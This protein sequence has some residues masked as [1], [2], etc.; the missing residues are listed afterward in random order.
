MNILVKFEATHF[1]LYIPDG[2]VYDLELLQNDFLKWIEDQSVYRV[3]PGQKTGICYNANT[4]LQY[5][6]EVVLLNSGERAY[7]IKHSK[8]KKIPTIVF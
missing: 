7:F 6:N 1:V 5:L 2:Y 3:L 4:F 8:Q